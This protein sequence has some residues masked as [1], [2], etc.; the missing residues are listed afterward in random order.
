MEYKSHII[1]NTRG[2]TVVVTH[3]PKM[4]YGCI[5]KTTFVS[6]KMI[7]SGSKLKVWQS[8][9][10]PMNDGSELPKRGQMCSVK[11]RFKHT[12]RTESTFYRSINYL[13]HISTPP[14]DCS[15]DLL[16]LR[17]SSRWH[18]DRRYQESLPLRLSHICRGELKHLYL[19]LEHLMCLGG[20]A[21]HAV[22]PLSSAILTRQRVVW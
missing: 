6:A 3:C 8:N 19:I 18:N 11:V 15:N 20:K 16:S 7:H 9:H 2:F 21:T 1:I 4:F 17:D 5:R 13:N 12:N 22:S 14:A 10:K